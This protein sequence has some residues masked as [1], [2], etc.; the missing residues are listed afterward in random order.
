ME[1]KQTHI[2]YGFISG[3]V[4]V[5]VSL[6]IYLTGVELT[7]WAQYLAFIPFLAGVVMDCIA[8]SKANDGFV[9][10]G[11]VFGSGFKTTMIITIVIIAWRVI[12]IYAFPEMKTRA[13]EMA[14]NQLAKN[15]Q[16]TDEQID[17][18]MN[19][20]RKFYNSITV[21]SALLSSLFYGAIF[22]LIGAAAA[23]KKGPKPFS[24]E[25]F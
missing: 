11:N 19:I 16:M 3:V 9:T 4:V 20:T 1:L 6:I 22:S 5:I 14:H 18:A 12:S 17:M 10:F 23:R 2:P 7:S 15:P 25:I 24:S 21:G 8:Y 13:I